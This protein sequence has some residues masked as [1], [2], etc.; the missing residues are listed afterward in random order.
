MLCG[1]TKSNHDNNRNWTQYVSLPQSKQEVV[2]G[3]EEEGGVEEDDV[4]FVEDVG[5]ADGGAETLLVF[6]VTF[7]LGTFSLG[8]FSFGVKGDSS[9]SNRRGTSDGMSSIV[10]SG[11]KGIQNQYIID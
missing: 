1:T 4:G 6:L 10:N 7:T 8:T 2:E 3:V 5:E 11:G 9:V